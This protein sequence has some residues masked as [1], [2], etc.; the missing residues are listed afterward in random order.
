MPVPPNVAVE[1]HPVAIEIVRAEARQARELT[2]IAFAAKRFWRYPEEWIRLWADELTVSAEYIDT[3]WVFAAVDGG[4][5]VGW[6]AVAKEGTEYWLDYCWVMPEATGKGLGS[7][8]AGR[9]F[10]LV[11]ELGSKTLKVIA[12]PNAEGFYTT[13]G[14]KRIGDYPSVPQGRLLPVMEAPVSAHARES[15]MEARGRGRTDSGGRRD[16]RRMEKSAMVDA[17]LHD[18]VREEIEGLH[19]FFVDWFSGA[20]PD[21]DDIFEAELLGRFDPRFCLIPPSGAALDLSEL[22]SM[23]RKGHGSNPDFRI[24]IRNLEVRT[25]GAS[26]VLGTYQEWQRNAL[27]STPPD[28][29]RVASAIL[30]CG[31][32]LRWLHVHETW[33]PEAV[34]VAGPYDF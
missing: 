6:F 34:M 31:D 8:L 12:D 29:G 18:Q 32:T 2:A 13:L 20:V 25:I 4:R 14:F 19:S 11:S 9:A 24:A 10:Q 3:N 5:T 22:T 15:C 23:V 30:H 21:S 1:R 16:C 27:A 26:H 7:R 28:N 33:L 17:A